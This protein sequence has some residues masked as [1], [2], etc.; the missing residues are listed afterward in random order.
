V[1]HLN[2]RSSS[3]SFWV[4][5]I[6]HIW[7]YSLRASAANPEMRSVHREAPVRSPQ[8]RWARASLLYET[9]LRAGGEMTNQ[10]ARRACT[11]AGVR[12]SKAALSV[13]VC[14]VCSL[15]DLYLTRKT[16]L[17]QDK[18]HRLWRL[19]LLW[20][21]ASSPSACFRAREA[22]KRTFT[23]KLWIWW[24]QVKSSSQKM[25]LSR[26]LSGWRTVC[27]VSVCRVER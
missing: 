24:L 2:I 3:H 23:R 17:T 26:C 8:L 16:L 15:S 10:R 22:I 27:S 13:W 14:L 9:C 11:W 4:L 7:H 5:N 21:F 6:S 18:T 25:L 20:C 12:I 19:E 1:H